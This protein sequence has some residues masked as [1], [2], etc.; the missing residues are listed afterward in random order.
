MKLTI[1][2]TL[3]TVFLSGA[4][5]SADETPAAPPQLPPP[6][7]ATTPS[8]LSTQPA[9]AEVVTTA[10]PPATSPSPAASPAR[11][12]SL[13]ETKPQLLGPLA[14]AAPVKF[15]YIDFQKI[16]RESTTAGKARKSLAASGEKMKKQLTAKGKKLE[17]LKKSLEGQAKQ[18]N[19][20]EQEAK[21]KDFQAKV[22]EYQETVQTAEKELAKQEEA[23]SRKLI[24]QVSKTV[25]E[26]GEKNG[27]T[28]ILTS[29]DLLYSDGNHPLN[30]VTADIIK[31]LDR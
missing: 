4:T 7:A 21:G 30:D 14:A 24:E 13:L 27:Y 25:K 10:A 28:L 20:L 8:P 12:P 18:M 31:L 1:F 19:Q 2:T 3:L 29:R 6:A 23:T 16:A 22:K 17:A 9:P 11:M 15:G 5:V 26:Y